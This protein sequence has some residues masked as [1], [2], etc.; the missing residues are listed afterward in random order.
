[1]ACKPQAIFYTCIGQYPPYCPAFTISN[2]PLGA[3]VNNSA[4]GYFDCNFASQHSVGTDQA[5]ATQLCHGYGWAGGNALRLK[6]VN[7][8]KCGYIIDKVTCY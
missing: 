1:M 7:G 4:D 8:N 5:A 3:H 6:S 2:P